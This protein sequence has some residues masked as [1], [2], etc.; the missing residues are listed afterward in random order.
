[1]RILSFLFLLSLLWFALPNQGFAV[2]VDQCD[3]G[4][5]DCLCPPGIGL[6]ELGIDNLDD[7]TTAEERCLLLCTAASNN[8]FY[9][10]ITHY[11]LQCDVQGIPSPVVE[12]PLPGGGSDTSTGEIEN[13]DP[14]VLGIDIPGFNPELS[15][16]Y[17]GGGSFQSNV[18]GEYVRAVYAWLI[19]AG[20]IVAVLMI[21]I[22]GVQYMMAG[23]SQGAI[24][25]AK[26]RM[27]NAVV[28]LILLL[29]AY[30]VAFLIDPNTVAFETLTLKYIEG[31]EFDYP[32]ETPGNFPV[33]GGSTAIDSEPAE[34]GIG[35]NGVPSYDQ[36]QFADTP[37]GETACFTASGGNVK[38]SGC[39]VTAYAMAASHLSGQTIDPPRVAN[40][41]SLPES[42]PGVGSAYGDRCRACKLGNCSDCNGTFGQAF[43][44]SNLQA[45]LGLRGEA[46]GVHNAPLSESDKDRVVELLSQGE[47]IIT[48]YRTDSGGGHYILLVG[49]NEDG[50]FLANNPWGGTKEVRDANA[51]WNVAKSFY[52]VY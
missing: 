4:T 34:A 18:L 35:W 42:C 5:I 50:N 16:S 27:R 8:P 47:L 3:E 36:T 52:H 10:A 9:D 31:I 21:M 39:G 29:G 49:L 6:G 11:K 45:E 24:G 12:L 38:S 32:N 23:G 17:F 13:V 14:P 30:T 2:T 51:Y 48:S 37:Y 1:M 28:G 20:A 46:I 41:W 33:G 26:E 40:A 7:P 15:D 44:N 43:F 22:G 25:Q 19:S